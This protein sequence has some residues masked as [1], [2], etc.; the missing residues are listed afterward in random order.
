LRKAGS[1]TQQQQLKIT[2]VRAPD[3]RPNWGINGRPRQ[4]QRMSVQRAEIGHSLLRAPTARLCR[5]QTF[6]L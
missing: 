5:Q 3:E 2:L 4:Q 1:S 6:I